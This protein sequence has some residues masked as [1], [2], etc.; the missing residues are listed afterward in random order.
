MPRDLPLGNG[1]LLVAFDNHYQIRDF[2]W[3]HVGQD[4]HAMGHPFRTGVWVEGQFRWFDDAGWQRDLGYEHETLVSKVNLA[5][6][7]LKLSIVAADAVDFHENVL[8]RRFDVTNHTHRAREVRLFFHH[9]L[10]IAGNEVGD[11]AYYEPDRRAVI[12][13]KGAN[14]FLANGALVQSEGDPAPGWVA[15]PDTAKGLVVGAHQWACGLKEV[16]NLQGTWRDAEDGQ[17]SGSAVAHGS[18]DSCIGFTLTIPAGQTRIVYSWLVVGS[19]FENVVALNR[20]ARQRGPQSF[21]DRTA[22]YW[23]LWL[24]RHR[25]DFQDLP[26]KIQDQYLTSLLVIRTQI[27]NDGAIIA[28]NDTDISSAVRDTYSY[29]W[30]RDGALVAQALTLAGYID[31][32]RAFFQ[33]CANV[34]TREGYLLHK[35]NP[36]GTLASSWHPWYREGHKDLPIQEDETALVLWALWNHFE[37]FGDV[38]FIKPLYKTLIATSAE[39]L[40]AYRDPETKLPLPSYDLWEERRGVLAWTVA[41]TWAGLNAAA[42]FAESFGDTTRAF[43]CRA[44]ADE[45]KAGVEKF[46]WRPERNCFARMINR[47]PDGNWEVDDALDASLT[48]LWLFGMYAPNDLKIVATMNAIR[49]RLWVKTDI[50]GV[51]RYQDDRYHQV[52][53]DLAN[54]PGNPWFISTLWLARWYAVTARSTSDLKRSLSLIE[55]VTEHALASGVLAEQVHPFSGAPLSVSPLTWSHAAFVSTVQTYL[56]TQKELKGA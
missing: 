12:H 3:P 2:Y 4:N 26:H 16:H 14:W 38:E 11:T 33:F 5:H 34:I 43:H 15:S 24:N 10:H 41:A 9:D 44:A 6:A 56:Q 1:N 28:A 27:D 13:Y 7:D 17:L 21:L 36:D 30:P 31:L 48:G 46:L 52:S 49:E 18:V 50:G 22:A 25:P 42:N 51:A 45:I 29:M 32:P 23:R 55:W 54:V 37:R 19:D 39:F 40:I 8:V 20:M 53:Q 47:A 35:Y